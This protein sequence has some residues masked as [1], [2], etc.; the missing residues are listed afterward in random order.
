MDE[1]L[2]QTLLSFEIDLW[3]AIGERIGYTID[4]V[5]IDC[6]PALRK[7]ISGDVDTCSQS[8]QHYAS[9]PAEVWFYA[10]VRTFS[11]FLSNRGWGQQWRMWKDLE[12]K[13]I[14]L[15][16][17]D[18]YPFARTKKGRNCWGWQTRLWPIWLQTAAIL[19]CIRS[20]SGWTLWKRSQR[21]STDKNT[22]R[23]TRRI[24]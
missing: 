9:A 5:R 4:F 17:V 2:T 16:E 22:C 8:G 23:K 12:G 19:I 10:A 3:N 21:K 11:V 1:V 24:L 15:R 14:A 7:W 18:A 20:G 6:L 13:G